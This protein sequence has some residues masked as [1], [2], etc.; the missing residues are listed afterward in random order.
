MVDFSAVQAVVQWIE[1][2][3]TTVDLIKWALVLVVA[4]LLGGFRFVRQRMR[5]PKA[6]L[7]THACRCLVEKFDEF[8]GHKG[9]VRTSYLLEV[10]LLNPT[11]EPVVIR[12]FSLAVRRHRKWRSR[13]PELRAITLPNRPR[14]AMGGGMKLMR[15]WFSNFPDEYRDL[16]LDGTVEPRQL[17]SGFLLFVDF[18]YG[19]HPTDL[20]K[21]CRCDCQDPPDYRRDVLR[22]R[23]GSRDGRSREVRTVGSRDS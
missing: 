4:W 21:L 14:Q 5:P 7:A 2:H 19:D 17:R 6:L 23:K 18:S 15:T 12:D 8:E 16:T 11:T 9:V 13:K 20:R 3:A 22:A 1:G 10:G